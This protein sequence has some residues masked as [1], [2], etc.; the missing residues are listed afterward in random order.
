MSN[1]ASSR[2]VDNNSYNKVC[3]WTDK[4]RCRRVFGA[5][6]DIT[7][8]F[9]NVGWY[10][11]SSRLAEIG[12]STRTIR[13]VKDYLA[14]RSVELL[15]EDKRYTRTLQKGCPQG[16]Q[17]GPIL[18]KVAMTGLTKIKLERTSLMV[19]YADD[20]AILVGAA[21]PPRHSPK[22]SYI[23]DKS[24]NERQILASIFR[25]RKASCYP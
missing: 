2:K 10:P 3:N 13:I 12:A 6:L 16:S 24:M 19:T 4:S 23:S 1:M 8:A 14:N 21:R 15:L 17:L 18:W 5:F 7:G 25:Q 9:D 20:I 22:W 11:M